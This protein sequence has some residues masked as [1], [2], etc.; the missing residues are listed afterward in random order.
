MELPWK[1]ENPRW[2]PEREQ[3]A[4]RPVTCPTAIT[5]A[6][7]AGASLQ[8]QRSD[9]VRPPAAFAPSAVSAGPGSPAA[10]PTPSPATADRVSVSHRPGGDRPRISIGRPGAGAA[11]LRTRLP[12]VAS[13]VRPCATGDGRLS[14]AA[15][16][17]GGEGRGGGRHPGKRGKS[18]SRSRR[19]RTHAREA[20]SPPT[21]THHAT[22]VN[23]PLT[24]ASTASLLPPPSSLPP[25]PRLRFLN[26]RTFFPSVTLHR[27]RLVITGPVTHAV[28]LRVPGK[29]LR[30]TELL[31]YALPSKCVASLGCT[32]EKGEGPGE[33]WSRSFFFRAD[34]FDRR[35]L[36]PKGATLGRCHWP[37]RSFPSPYLSLSASAL[38]S[39]E[40]RQL[41]LRSPPFL[42]RSVSLPLLLPRLGVNGACHRQVLHAGGRF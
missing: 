32:G 40:R 30:G 8:R 7:T 19:N 16:A 25:P 21:H 26:P 9:D 24:F 36:P 11:E 29:S 31:R 38:I 23:E 33:T 28:R 41:R 37:G 5:G 12:V 27:V 2:R 39:C 15:L 3:P 17:S 13:W 42:S 20:N 14:L 34:R 10:G 4:P 6:V 22:Y 35:H 18:F 1:T